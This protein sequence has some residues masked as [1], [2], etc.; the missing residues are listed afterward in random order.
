MKFLTKINRNLFVTLVVILV[1][2]SVIGYFVLQFIITNEAKETLLNEEVVVVNQIAET[3]EIPNIYPLI[4]ITKIERITS[5][6]AEFH[7]IFIRNEQEDESEPFLEYSNQV[8]INES[9]YQIKLRRSLFESEDLVLMLSLILFILIFSSFLIMFFISKKMNKTVWSDFELNLREIEVFSFDLNKNIKLHPTH[10]EEFDRLNKVITGLTEKLMSDYQSLRQF[11]ENA[12]HEIQTP[13]SIALLNLD[14]LLQENLDEEA[15]QKV[16]SSINALKRLSSLNE[17]LILLTKIENKQF[18]ADKAIS[19]NEIIR[20]KLLEFDSLLVMKKLKVDLQSG[21]E[22]E[23]K[24]N[25]Q[26][27]DI[28]IG[29]L[30]SNAVNH[31]IRGGKITISIQDKILKICNSGESNDFSGENIFNRFSKGN[32]KSYGLGLAIVKD[33]CTTHNLDINYHKNELHCFT[34]RPKI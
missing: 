17:S 10:I 34:I 19:L 2:I 16:V 8:K 30:L 4:A 21:A 32:S 28:L 14:E 12:S 15:F 9:F 20:R 6:Q 1:L 18:K 26:L 23:L 25:E 31:N 22:F 27:A 7:K 33:I 3:G 24:I 5:D 13:L 29:N 11:S